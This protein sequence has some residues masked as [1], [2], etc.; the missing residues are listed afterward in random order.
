MTQKIQ[1]KDSKNELSEKT[2]EIIRNNINTNNDF[3]DLQF[4]KKKC[5]YS[6]FENTNTTNENSAGKKE[7]IEAKNICIIN[8]YEDNYLE[9]INKFIDYPRIDDLNIHEREEGN[10]DKLLYFRISRYLNEL[11]TR[12]ERLN[13]I[14]KSSVFDIITEYRRIENDSKF[15]MQELY[16]SRLEILIQ[17]LKNP[18]IIN[19]KRKLI[20]VLIF[21][22]YSENQEYFE[23]NENYT[24]STQNLKELENL[25]N[26]KLTNNKDNKDIKKDLEKL[27]AISRNIDFNCDIKDAKIEKEVKDDKKGI[28]KEINKNINK[29]LKNQIYL[30]K[31]FLE[32][33]KKEL[34][35]DV[36]ISKNKADLYLL[37]RSLFNSEVKSSEYLLDLEAIIGGENEKAEKEEKNEI[38]GMKKKRKKEIDFQLYSMNKY[39]T[40]DEALNILFSFKSKFNFI[41]NKTFKELLKKQIDFENNIE[42]AYN[43]FINLFSTRTSFNGAKLN[44]SKEVNEKI[45]EYVG[46]FE[47]N[48]LSKMYKAMESLFIDNKKFD[49]KIIDTIRIFF[50][51]FKDNCDCELD[52]YET[53][54]NVEKESQILYFLKIKA[55]I[56]E[57]II[58]FFENI[59]DKI[60]QCLIE[61]EKKHKEIVAKIISNIKTL[62]NYI[63]TKNESKNEFKIYN[64][65][66]LERNYSNDSEL[67]NLKLYFKKFIKKK[68]NLE[69]NYTYDSQFCLWAI[70]NE[71]GIYFD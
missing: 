21:H 65:W 19:I 61:K 46:N 11:N 39:L 43:F 13:Y 57:K 47:E 62:K 29:L 49:I 28:K 63:K 33:Y 24:P 64:N 6:L 70:K 26:D 68:I 20:E 55:I 17:L 1:I 18:N 48:V 14:L 52:K 38:I 42:K 4:N 34:N 22:L 45:M 9:G 2:I 16:N 56:I 59:K 25:I 37:P 44:F 53:N 67:K 5:D 35:P 32:Y 66:R 36:R 50:D 30:I 60:I 69:M 71:F 12:I 10:N 8:C 40:V 58:I 51:N 3:V 23:L 41:E 54:Y 15:R 7:K 27:K 31:N